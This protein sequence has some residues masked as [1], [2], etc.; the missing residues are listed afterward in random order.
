MEKTQLTISRNLP[1]L[2]L[3][4]LQE[5]YQFLSSLTK[6]KVLITTN[7]YRLNSLDELPQL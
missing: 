7:D 5:I 6:G 2:H 1:P 4:E 3:D